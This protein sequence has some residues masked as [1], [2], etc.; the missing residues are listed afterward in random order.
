MIEHL[1]N[2][3]W[4]EGSAHIFGVRGLR[5]HSNAGSILVLLCRFK[6]APINYSWQGKDRLH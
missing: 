1:T 4:N 5:L 3:E 2:T 6:N